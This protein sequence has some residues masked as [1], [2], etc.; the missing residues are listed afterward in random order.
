MR[1]APEEFRDHVLCL[2]CGLYGC[3]PEVYQ[4]KRLYESGCR[5]IKQCPKCFEKSQSALPRLFPA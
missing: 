3:E 1:E 4:A 2:E 5:A